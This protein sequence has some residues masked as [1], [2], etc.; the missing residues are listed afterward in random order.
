M[1]ASRKGAR[2]EHDLLLN[3]ALSELAEVVSSWRPVR[4]SGLV[5]HSDRGAQYVSIKYTERLLEAGVDPSIGSVGS[6][7][8]FAGLPNKRIESYRGV[9][10][11]SPTRLLCSA[12]SSGSRMT[13]SW[14]F[15]SV[16]ATIA[17]QG[18][19]S[20]GLYG[21]WGTSAGI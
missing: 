10:R 17:T 7:T 19:V 11:R 5:H 16:R 18:V 4:K 8:R 2:R 9:T 1:D 14:S 20:L 12:S 6:S 21:R 15:G 3:T 13:L